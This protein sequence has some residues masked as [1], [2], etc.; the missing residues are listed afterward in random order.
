MR[1]KTFYDVDKDVLV[2][3]IIPNIQ[4]P[5][6]K[7]I[8]RLEEVIKQ[9]GI[10]FCNMQPE[11]PY[12]EKQIF[13]QSTCT[14]SCRKNYCFD[15]IFTCEYCANRMCDKCC[16]DFG[17]NCKGCDALVCGK[18]DQGMCEQ[19]EDYACKMCRAK[20]VLCGQRKCWCQTVYCDEN[21][22]AVLDCVYFND[23]TQDDTTCID[24]RPLISCAISG[25]SIVDAVIEN[26]RYYR[27]G[28]G[29]YCGKCS[30]NW[31][32]VEHEPYNTDKNGVYV[33]WICNEQK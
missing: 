22:R 5:L 17:R 4:Q 33:C 13:G 32:C 2:T 30:E 8:N 23:G 6:L 21:L 20:C 10:T 12:C 16:G 24:C 26:G 28:T 7:K 11:Y 14:S 25:C 31:L 15:H 3:H 19:C 29:V 1:K 9:S 18:C 27:C